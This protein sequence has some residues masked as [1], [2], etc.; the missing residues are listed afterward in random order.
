MKCGR[1]ERDVSHATRDL[2]TNIQIKPRN[3]MLGDRR[4]RGLAAST[5]GTA[6]PIV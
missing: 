5:S 4:E 1:G 3:P 6:A 2:K